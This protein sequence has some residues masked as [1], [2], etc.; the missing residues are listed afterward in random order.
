MNANNIDSTSATKL[1]FHRL[2]QEYAWAYARG[3][4][5]VLAWR[6]FD[7]QEMPIVTNSMMEVPSFVFIQSGETLRLSL[8]DTVGSLIR[9]TC[10]PYKSLAGTPQML[11]GH[12]YEV[13]QR[14]GLVR[15]SKDPEIEFYRH[16]RNGCFHGNRFKFMNNEPENPAKW[17]GKEITRVMEGNKVFPEKEKDSDCFLNW[18][19]PLILLSDISKKLNQ[20][21]V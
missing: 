1:E 21:T 18:G 17:R 2:I 8:N 11:V 15:K 19:D 4:S 6:L 12:T 14:N 20:G 16:T 3:I 9:G 5:G 7:K 13:L 10:D